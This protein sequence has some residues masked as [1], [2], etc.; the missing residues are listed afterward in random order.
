MSPIQTI[1]EIRDT[2]NYQGAAVAMCNM[3]WLA[4]G[5][6]LNGRYVDAQALWQ[7]AFTFVRGGETAIAVDLMDRAAKIAATLSFKGADQ[8]MLQVLERDRWRYLLFVD[9]AWA[10]L[11]GQTPD[12]M[13]VVSRY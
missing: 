3:G 6:V 2:G 12:D 13:L 7:M 11:S 9:I 10:A 4:Q 1:L 8:G 5:A